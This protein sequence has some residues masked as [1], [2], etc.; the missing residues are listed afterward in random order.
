M[1]KEGLKYG[2]NDLSVIPSV[3]TSVESRKE[4]NPYCWG[5]DTIEKD[6]L[7][8]FASPM[9]AVVSDKNYKQFIDNKIMP[10]IP[11]TKNIPYEKRCEL[12]KESCWI[13]FSLKEFENLFK[14]DDYN[15]LENVNI[16]RICIDIANGHMEK[17]YET[18]R[19][20]KLKAIQD[21]KDLI[22]MT[23]NIANPE[24]YRKLCCMNG[25]F[26]METSGYFLVEYIRIGIGG[27]AGCIT[28]SNVA[29]HYPQASLIEECYEIKR[30]Y[31]CHPRIIADG[32]I[33]GYADV[34]KALA[35]GADY[36]MIGSLFS[37]MIESAGKKIIKPIGVR[38]GPEEIEEYTEL[39]YN[40]RD[41][42]WYGKS[43]WY[44]GVMVNVGHIDVVFFGM[45]SADGQISMNGEKTKT[46]EG[47]TKILPVVYSMGK[48]SENMDSYIRSA[49]SYCNCYNLNDFIGKVDLVVNSVSEINA[50][51]K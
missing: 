33:R 38:K 18:I 16:M 36:T 44:P 9:A 31:P 21:G 13:A 26:V 15:C 47:I 51:N 25:D 14:S 34:I 8:I 6:M 23:G 35:L 24:A 20:A 37:Q 10:I 28:T 19:K 12:L 4:C 2:Y 50:V 32:G 17:L 30:H 27:G 1:I 48:W 41:E 7:P 42:C 22:I 3:L 43:D 46:A 39:Q 45:A 49:M 11:R 29:I 40:N 5:F